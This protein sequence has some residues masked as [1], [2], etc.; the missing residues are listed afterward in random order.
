[1]S[2]AVTVELSDEMYGQLVR[3]AQLTDEPL[4]TIVAHSLAH[5]LPPLLEDI[6]PIYQADVYPLLPMDS[7]ALRAEAARRFPAERW[8]LYEA[9]LER[10]RQGVLLPDEEAQLQALKREADVLTF[11]KAYAAVLLKRRG[12]RV[13]LDTLAG[14]A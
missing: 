5:S 1:M 4:G 11:R 10:K 3:A 8:A 14:E 7:H 13:T 2:Q 9:L 6:P 12:Y